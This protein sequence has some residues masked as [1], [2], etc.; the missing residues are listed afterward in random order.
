MSYEPT[1]EA[2]DM[3][4]MYQVPEEGCCLACANSEPGCLCY[5]CQCSKCDYYTGNSCGLA[6]EWREDN[7]A[8]MASNLQIK[9]TTIYKNTLIEIKTTGPVV[10]SD[11]AKLKPFLLTHF[12][13]NH[14]KKCYEQFSENWRFV[15]LLRQ[16]VKKCG[17][18]PSE[19]IVEGT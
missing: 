3:S 16:T 15:R 17:F 6:D 14:L 4:V 5:Q 9:F 19:L 8:K 12:R 10:K 1:D 7:Y 2:H 13:Y 11:Y 18:N